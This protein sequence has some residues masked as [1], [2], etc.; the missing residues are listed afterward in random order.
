[1]GRIEFSSWSLVRSQRFVCWSHCSLNPDNVIV[2][3]VPE[4]PRDLDLLDDCQMLTMLLRKVVREQ[5]NLNLNEAFLV[6]KR[7]VMQICVMKWDAMAPI[8]IDR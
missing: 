6:V 4:A 7:Q 5:P 8:E 1:V 2:I 3:P